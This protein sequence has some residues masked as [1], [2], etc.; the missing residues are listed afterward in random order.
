MQ[1]MTEK[2]YRLAGVEL[3]VSLPTERM[4]EEELMLAPFRVD[5]VADPHRFC[6]TL[7]ETLPPPQG[8]EIAALP[9]CRVYQ[10]GQETVR[11]IGSVQQGWDRAYI[12]A[13]HQG[14][15]H[16]VQLKADQ[17]PARVG[18]KTV[19]NALGIEHLVVRQ[20]GV[21]LHASYV[22]WQG[23]GILFTAPSGTGKSTQAEL[24]RELRGGEIINGDRA[25]IRLADGAVQAAGIPFS[26]SSCYCGNRTLP[27][28][29]I[30]YLQ[31]T[32]QTTIRALHGFQ[33]FR[34]VWEGCSVNT[35]DGTDMALASDT[36]Q[37]AVSRVPVYLLACTPDESAV[38]ALQQMLRE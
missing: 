1:M 31:Q 30:V 27:L 22:A 4:Y 9:G 36:V 35:W 8:E 2:Y 38:N 16:A 5:S 10:Q 32:P 14:Q 6:V 23:R 21:I 15:H 28:A 13:S 24:W 11:Y 17:F 18:V 7:S 37:Q 19:L 29:A 12:R 26:G 3:A 34:R 33:A 20:Q 25:V